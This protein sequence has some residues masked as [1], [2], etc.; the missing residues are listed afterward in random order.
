MHLEGQHRAAGA[1][2][3]LGRFECRPVRDAGGRGDRPA[4]ALVAGRLPSIALAMSKARLAE[5]GQRPS[6]A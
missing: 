2:D 5:V 6:P 3:R 4:F 1:A